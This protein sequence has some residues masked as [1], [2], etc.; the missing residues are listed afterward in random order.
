MVSSSGPFL[1]I[2]IVQ[3]KVLNKECSIL[4]TNLSVYIYPF[5]PKKYA[6]FYNP[7]STST[8]LWIYRASILK[9]HKILR[10]KGI[11]AQFTSFKKKPLKVSY[12]MVSSSGPFLSPRPTE[13]SGWL[14]CEAWGVRSEAVDLRTW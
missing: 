3:T 7:N 11:G 14:L 2:Y 9:L 5:T 4:V 6:T 8:P 10:D 12:I 13:H 1:S